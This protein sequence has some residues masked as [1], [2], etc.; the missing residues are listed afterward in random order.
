M[1]I[2]KSA[3]LITTDTA[4]VIYGRSQVAGTREIIR[5]DIEVYRVTYTT[6]DTD[7]E[8][9]VAS[10]AILI[11]KT[12]GRLQWMCYGRGTRYIPGHGERSAPSY[13]NLD[14]NQS[15]YENY[16]MSFLAATFASAASSS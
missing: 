10:G 14:N 13:Y 2:L 16:E 8:E 4:A 1:S 3:E 5:H 12:H 6:R 9:V 7:G 15:I 11:P